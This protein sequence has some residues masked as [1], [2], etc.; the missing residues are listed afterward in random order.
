MAFVLP[1]KFQDEVPVWLRSGQRE[2]E[3]PPLRFGRD[4]KGFFVGLRV[5]GDGGFASMLTHLR[6]RG[7]GSPRLVLLSFQFEMD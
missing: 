5:A 6:L 2:K 7:D 1:L 3:I 4:D